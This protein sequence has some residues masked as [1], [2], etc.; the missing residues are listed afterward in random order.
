M[1]FQSFLNDSLVFRPIKYVTCVFVKYQTGA[2]ADHS[3]G[4]FFVLKKQSFHSYCPNVFHVV[5]IFVK[6]QIAAICNKC[7]EAIT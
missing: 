3:L 2:I 4:V 7:F 6:Y 5:Y 1:Y